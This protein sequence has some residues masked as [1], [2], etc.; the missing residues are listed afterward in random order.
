MMKLVSTKSNR[1]LQFLE[2][3][4]KLFNA[5]H[6]VINTTVTKQNRELKYEDFRGTKYVN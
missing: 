6:L 1:T 5:T 4:R 2:L 3:A